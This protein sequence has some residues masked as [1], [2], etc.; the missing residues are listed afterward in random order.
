MPYTDDSPQARAGKISGERRRAAAE[1]RRRAQ[2][3]REARERVAAV[4]AMNAELAVEQTL[5]RSIAR[6]GGR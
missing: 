4:Q 3:A 6:G 2:E 1:Q 5:D